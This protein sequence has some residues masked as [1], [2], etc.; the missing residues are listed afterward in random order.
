MVR[1]ARR[2]PEKLLPQLLVLFL[3]ICVVAEHARA[4]ALVIS[5]SHGCS[6][7]LRVPSLRVRNAVAEAAV[8]LGVLLVLSRLI[9]IEILLGPRVPSSNLRLLLRK[10]RILDCLCGLYEAMLPIISA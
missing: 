1:P 6:L 7:V 5:L 10:R 3:A 9:F 4:A 8:H 2:R